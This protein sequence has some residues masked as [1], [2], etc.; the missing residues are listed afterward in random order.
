VTTAHRRVLAL[1]GVALYFEGYGRSLV[2]VTLPHIGRDLG[3]PAPALAYA[4]ALIAAGS[5]GA[6]VLGPV[7]DSLGRRR[8]LLGC[9]ALYSVLGAA[10][11]SAPTLPALVLWQ[12]AARLFQEGA[13]FSAAVVAAE[14]MPAATRAEAQGIL[15]AV[16]SCG[17]GTVAFLLVFIGVVPWG[18]RGL[19]LVALLPLGLLPLF[20]RTIPETTRWLARTPFA[21]ARLPAGAGGRLAAALAVVLLAMAYDVAGFAFATYVPVEI[22]GWSGAEAGTMV[23]VA[24]AIGLPGWWLGG[25]LAGARG[26]RGAA[27]LFLVGLSAAEALFFL[28]G[29]HALGPAFAAMVFCQGGKTTV[30]RAWATEL[31]PTTVRATATGALAAGATLGGMAG[32]AAAGALAPRVGGIAPALVV[33]ATSGVAA[34][35]L[36]WLCLPETK[37]IELE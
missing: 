35:A 18:W 31:F 8:L 6:L 16:N 3:L 13:L 17:S 21:L 28:G 19:C 30:L 36:A 1:L 10:T 27:V 23:V 12:A 15:G 24:G 29:P 37:G 33:V 7:A 25:R 32:L 2:T 26:R 5:L 9:I 4:L 22:H 34:A 14:E 11:A 20:R